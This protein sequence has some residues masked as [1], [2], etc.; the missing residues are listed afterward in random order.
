MN[1]ADQVKN[2]IVEFLQYPKSLERLGI[3]STCDKLDK[4]SLRCHECGCDMKLK[5]LVPA[6]KCPLGKW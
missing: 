2:Q 1:I 6:L 4:Q 3:C 5:V